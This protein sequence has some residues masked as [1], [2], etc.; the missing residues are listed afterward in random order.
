MDPRHLL[1]LPPFPTPGFSAGLR[2]RSAKRPE[3]GWQRKEQGQGV[4]AEAEER[5]APG[6]ERLLALLLKA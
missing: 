4:C 2:R 1:L 5:R 3:R 6:G